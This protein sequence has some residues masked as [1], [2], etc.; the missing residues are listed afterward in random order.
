MLGPTRIPQ[1]LPLGVRSTAS[2]DGQPSFSGG[3]TQIK[4]VAAKVGSFIWGSSDSS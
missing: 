4:D 1:L 2:L 3:S